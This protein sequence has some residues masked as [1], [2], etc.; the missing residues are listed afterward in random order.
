MVDSSNESKRMIVSDT[1]K[2]AAQQLVRVTPISDE[3]AEIPGYKK[4]YVAKSDN[5]RVQAIYHFTEGEVRYVVGPL[6]K[7]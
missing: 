5:Q 4:M 3:I 7:T 6:K 1:I 2:S